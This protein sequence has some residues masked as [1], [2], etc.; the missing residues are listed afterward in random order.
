MRDSFL[1]T[2]LKT[3]KTRNS[4]ALHE[5]SGDSEIAYVPVIGTQFFKQDLV[6]W[7]HLPIWL[8]L[9]YRSISLLTSQYVE[10]GSSQTKTQSRQ[11]T[12]RA[13]EHG[14]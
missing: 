6:D 11:N 1:S 7:S 4:K 13:E 8:T 2:R 3:G 5:Q 14:H 12:S 9:I 10:I